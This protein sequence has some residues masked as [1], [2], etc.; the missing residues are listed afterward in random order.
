[1][2]PIARLH[3]ASATLPTANIARIG[4]HRQSRWYVETIVA[5]CD[6]QLLL[7]VSIVGARRRQLNFFGRASGRSCRTYPSRDRL[8]WHSL[9]RRALSSPRRNVRG[10]IRFHLPID[11]S[12][13]VTDARWEYG[14]STPRGCE[15]CRASP[16]RSTTTAARYA[17]KYWRSLLRPLEA[18]FLEIDN[19]ASERP[20]SR[21]G[22]K[23][24]LRR[25]E[26]PIPTI[27][28]TWT[29]A[30]AARTSALSGSTAATGPPSV[31]PPRVYASQ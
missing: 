19:G 23:G 8:L 21:P 28:P 31:G 25:Y 27:A 7:G 24:W 2:A 17:L 1:M 22:R 10:S 13:D 18:G 6:E 12:V 30:R 26:E 15:L 9:I 5:R 4:Q 3:P 16:T 14:R 11:A 29:P 20:T